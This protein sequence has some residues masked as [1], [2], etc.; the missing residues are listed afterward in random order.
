MELGNLLN[1]TYG[2]HVILGAYNHVGAEKNPTEQPD[3]QSQMI[4]QYLVNGKIVDGRQNASYADEAISTVQMFA[5]EAL[6]IKDK[7][8]QML[9][10]AEEANKT[11]G[12]GSG[13]ELEQMQQELEQLAQEINDIVNSTEYN[14]NKLF[15]KEGK[16]IS[17]SIGNRSTIDIVPK[18][19]SIDVEG[20]DLTTDPDRVLATV[21]WKAADSN[22]YSGYL[23]DQVSRLDSAWKLIE[24]EQYNDLG[25]KPDEFNVELAKQVAA[26]ASIQTSDALSALFDAQANVE[27]D[28]VLE[29]LRDVMA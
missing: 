11:K 5:G 12:K 4:V 2:A 3:D 6:V 24:F 18:D 17:I 9:E 8:A 23:A 7:Y 15:T 26:Y 25:F 21:Q 29:L 16:T 19:L 20:L 27:P 1:V 10:L 13:K 22:Y 28:R 14:G